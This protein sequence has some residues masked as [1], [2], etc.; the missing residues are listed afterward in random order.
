MMKESQTNQRIF[1]AAV[2]L[3]NTKGYSG[4]SVREIAK[5]ADINIALISYYFDG[6]QGLLEQ[7]MTTFFDGYIEKLEIAT[8]LSDQF[9]IK[10][11]LHKA[12]QDLITYQQKNH[13]LARLVHRET[14]IDSVLIRE[15]MALYL[16][17]EKY[18]WKTLLQK[19]FQSGEFKKQPVDLIIIQLKSMLIMPYLHPQYLQE[20]FHVSPSDDYFTRRYSAC[21][22]DWMANHV[23]I[24]EKSAVQKND[25]Y[26]YP[27]SI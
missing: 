14:T 23:C 11:C 12:I 22:Q 13:Q 24:D 7:L 10:E 15:V 25:F 19:G 5:R 26:H 2:S 6:K 8:K 27:A 1:E 16:R 3:F 20:I 21:L 18:Y 4:T 9:S 17:K